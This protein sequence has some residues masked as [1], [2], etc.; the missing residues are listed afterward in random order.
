MTFP[1]E[2]QEPN[3]KSMFMGLCNYLARE[4][5]KRV[6]ESSSTATIRADTY[7]RA[8]AYAEGVASVYGV[9]IP[10]PGDVRCSDE[11]AG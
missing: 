7:R 3:W 8:H 6:F 4:S 10:Q 5:T 11:S 9:T 1:L 2:D